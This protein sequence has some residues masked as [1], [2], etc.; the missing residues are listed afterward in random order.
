MKNTI[1]IERVNALTDGVIAIALTLLVIGID[2]PEDHNFGD[3]GLMAFLKKLAPDMVTYLSSFLVIAIY[4]MLHHRVFNEIKH[5]NSTV[6][7]LNCLF[8]FSISFVPF[9]SRLKTAYLY[10]P[11]VVGIISAV[12]SFT[13]VMLLLIWKYVNRNKILLLNPVSV[14]KRKYITHKIVHVPMV[15]VFTVLLATLDEHFGAY[16]FMV[17]PVIYLLM[18]RWDVDED[19][20]DD[21]KVKK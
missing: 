9:V 4:W 14:T 13:A 7:V 16:F 2:V 17:T 5:I 8:L 1:G 11:A 15:C 20:N 3:D 19:F 10:D 12:H 18:M 21:G 6:M